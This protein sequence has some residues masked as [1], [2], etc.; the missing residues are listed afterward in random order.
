MAQKGVITTQYSMGPIEELGLLK[1]DFLG[2][3]NLTIIKRCISA[4]ESDGLQVPDME[5]LDLGDTA[6]YELLLKGRSMGVFQLESNGMQNLLK[7]LQPSRFDDIIAILAL[8]RP[9]PL[10]SGIDPPQYQH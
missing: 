5:N 8:Y 3:K 6:V 7:R 2:L 1:M 4:M 10:D 9:G